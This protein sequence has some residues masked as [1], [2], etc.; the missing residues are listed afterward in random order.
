MLTKTDGPSLHLSCPLLGNDAI[1]CSKTPQ[2][3]LTDW[4]CCYIS[5]AEMVLKSTRQSGKRRTNKTKLDLCLSA[6]YSGNSLSWK[7][8]SEQLGCPFRNAY[9][10]LSNSSAICKYGIGLLSLLSNNHQESNHC[11][12]ADFIFLYFIFHLKVNDWMGILLFIPF[13]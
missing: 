8:N 4:G 2:L 12:L 6:E 10:L 9:S 13:S 5:I 11:S 1:C 7:Y 3:S